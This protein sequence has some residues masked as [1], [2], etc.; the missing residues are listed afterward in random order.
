MGNIFDSSP[1]TEVMSHVRLLKAHAIQRNNIRYNINEIK[2]KKELWAYNTSFKESKELANTSKIISVKLSQCLEIK[3][4]FK[5]NVIH[6]PKTIDFNEYNSN[7]EE[8]SLTE[9]QFQAF[10]EIYAQDLDKK[11]ILKEK[12]EF[13]QEKAR[14]KAKVYSDNKKLIERINKEESGINKHSFYCNIAWT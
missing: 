3:N 11:R 12:L 4:S 13:L 8:S 14:N 5:S 7:K 6:K 2:I 9:S 1:D 10:S